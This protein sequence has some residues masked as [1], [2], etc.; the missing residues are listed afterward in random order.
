MTSSW[1]VEMRGLGTLLEVGTVHVSSDITSTYSLLRSIR[2][3]GFCVVGVQKCCCHPVTGSTQ[4]ELALTLF[5]N[6]D[7]S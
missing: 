2:K 7:L 5:R 3:K 1:Q 6:E 4:V